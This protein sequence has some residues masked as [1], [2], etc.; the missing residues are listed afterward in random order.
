[1][2][3]DQSRNVH[4]NKGTYSPKA[5]MLMKNKLLNAHERLCGERGKRTARS[6]H[7]N[8]D[9][10]RKHRAWG[11]SKIFKVENE[12]ESHD[13]IENKGWNFLTHDVYDK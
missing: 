1:L 10:G 5:G 12:G 6:S 9:V 7:P 4:E 11:E 8:A 2:E 13:V 3:Y